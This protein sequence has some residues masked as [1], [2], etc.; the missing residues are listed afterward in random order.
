MYL[1][2]K[3]I[4][5]QLHYYIRDTYQD[6][7]CLKSRD[8]FYLGTDP[9]RYIVYTS[10]HGYYFDEVI[11]ETLAQFD[12]YP[13]QDEL[14]RV[15]WDFLDPEIKRVIV[16]FQRSYAEPKPALQHTGPPP[17]LFDK[18]RL[19]FLRFAE[20]GQRNLDRLPAKIFRVL[21][22]KSRD[23]IEQYFWEQERILR[24]HEK[25]AYIYTIFD[26]QRFFP[27][28]TAAGR[29]QGL[30]QNKMDDFFIEAIC[31]LNADETFWSGMAISD[32]LS[33]YLVK[34]AVMYFDYGFPEVSPLQHDLYEF[35][36]R[37]RSYI[38]PK[39][40]RLNMA[41]AARLFETRWEK[42]KGM[43][44]RSLTRLYRKMAL[45]HHPDRGG[46]QETF[47]KLTRYYQ[48]IVSKKIR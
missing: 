1:A 15:F 8:V 32:R 9:S 22:G 19:H 33:E 35:M 20:M 17:H 7:R 44:I 26:L 5:S 23:E 36:N 11:E 16:G 13:D 27:E 2:R 47:V 42:L 25:K 39:K 34:Y 14:E 46:K 4:N 45:K 40:V 3:T 38:P 43:D 18:R 10:G 30:S 41:D 6:G 28:R 31:K 48:G 21:Y 37:H 29:P 12:L 24:P